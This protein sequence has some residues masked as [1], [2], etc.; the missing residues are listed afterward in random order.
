M[1][2]TRLQFIILQKKNIINKTIDEVCQR[3]NPAGRP[4][5]LS[6]R[7]KKTII[8]VIESG[9]CDTAVEVSKYLSKYHKKIISA[10]TIR[11]TLQ[12]SGLKSSK[13]VKKPFLS[14]R[15]SKERFDFSKRYKDWT[16][17]DWRQVFWSDETKIN[18]FSSDGTKWFWK[19][20]K[21]MIKSRNVDGTLKFGGGSIMIW[22]CMTQYG[23]G[24]ITRI[25]GSLN[26]ELYCDILKDEL[27]KTLKIY[28]IPFKN[29]IV[30]HDN[31]PKHTSKI[32][33]NCL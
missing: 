5:K 32:H 7:D 1:E 28:G 13:K 3:K 4:K 10:S 22:G 21:E 12:K 2:F 18:R 14:S 8:S 23:P 16:V 20:K 17:H 24:L 31:D 19:S 25:D 33:K 30:Q 15:H 26:G 9:E 27:V 29:I 6:E 11:R